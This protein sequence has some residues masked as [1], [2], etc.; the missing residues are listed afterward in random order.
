MKR[1]RKWNFNFNFNILGNLWTICGTASQDWQFT[2]H[3]FI[4]GFEIS[5]GFYGF[6]VQKFC[7]QA[8]KTAKRVDH[9]AKIFQTSFRG[10]KQ[11]RVEFTNELWS[12]VIRY[13]QYFDQ[14]SEVFDKLV[15]GNRTHD[16][17]QA[18]ANLLKLQQSQGILGK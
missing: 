3:A 16:F 12:P 18:G 2:K 1:G 5:E 7:K 10:I 11:R 13:L 9:F 8:R 15:M 6:R 17:S 14:T 4:R